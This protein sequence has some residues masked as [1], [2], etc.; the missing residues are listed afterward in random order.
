MLGAPMNDGYLCVSFTATTGNAVDNICELLKP[1]GLSVTIPNSE[2]VSVWND[3]GTQTTT[4]MHGLRSL[5]DKKAAAN[6]QFWYSQDEDLFCNLRCDGQVV[7][8]ELA[9]D[10]LDLL[11][12]RELFQTL[13]RFG[14]ATRPSRMNWL[15]YDRNG[16]LAGFDWAQLTSRSLFENECFAR[17]QAV[18]AK[19]DDNELVAVADNTTTV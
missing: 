13:L 4:T 16:E 3:D 17:L 10:G 15:V 11:Q 19:N 2:S 5:V 12:E 1:L 6:F 18:Y 14:T 8:C 7:I 9:L